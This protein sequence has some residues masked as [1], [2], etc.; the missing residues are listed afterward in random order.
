MI[1]LN[2]KRGRKLERTTCIKQGFAPPP[3]IEC[4]KSKVKKD[5][6][7]TRID[8]YE[9]LC[10]QQ[11]IVHK[12]GKIKKKKKKVKKINNDNKLTEPGF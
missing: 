10:P 4:K 3:P 2:L 6:I 1:Q 12:G 11:M 5:D 7:D 9:T 8:V